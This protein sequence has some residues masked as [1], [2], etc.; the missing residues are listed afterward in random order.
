[1]GKAGLATKKQD[2]H[3]ESGLTLLELLIVISILGMLAV[4]AAVPLSRYLGKS[5]TDTASLQ[6]GQLDVALDLFRLDVGR[7]PTPEEGLTALL[8]KPATAP[9]WNGPYLKKRAAIADPWGKAFH[10]RIPGEHGEYD[11]YS[12]G[13]DG[14]AGGEG[15]NGDVAGWDKN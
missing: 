5:K 1:M 12:L 15:E 8:A 4:V 10:Y 6:I 2:W 13:A 14:Q 3:S 11:I 9:K 7:L